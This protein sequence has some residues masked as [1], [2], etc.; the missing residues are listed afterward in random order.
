MAAVEPGLNLRGDSRVA[1]PARLVNRLAEGGA[2]LAALIAVALLGIVVW[3]V[4]KRG[5]GEL[6]WAS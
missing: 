2:T 3:S 6:S 5:A 4:A 1:A